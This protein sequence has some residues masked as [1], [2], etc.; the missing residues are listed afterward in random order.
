[1]NPTSVATSFAIFLLACACSVESKKFTRCGLVQELIFHQFTDL[2]NWICLIEA[3]SDRNT[4]AIHNDGGKAKYGLFQ[5]DTDWCSDK[6][7]PAKKCFVKCQSLIS[8]DISK[9]VDCAQK[10]YTAGGFKMFQAW[11]DN[12]EGKPLPDLS[13]CF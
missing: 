2:A 5:I 11:R 8:D 10:M 12:C 9:S 6:W 4:G 3:G 13:P 7:Y 1:M